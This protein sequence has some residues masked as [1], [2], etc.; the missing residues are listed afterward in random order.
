MR[1]RAAVLITTAVVGVL[2]FSSSSAQTFRVERKEQGFLLTDRYPTGDFQV[3]LRLKIEQQ[4]SILDS[5]GIDAAPVGSW[6]LFASADGHIAFNLWDGRNWSQILSNEVMPWG[7]ETMVTV[8]RVGDAVTV[9][10][11]G[12]WVRKT[13]GTPLSGKPVYVG[14]YSPDA[15]WGS[16]YDIHR[17]AIGQI[18]VLYIGPPKSYPPNFS[19]YRSRIRDDRAILSEGDIRLLESAIRTLKERKGWDVGVAFLKEAEGSVGN[20]MM[21]SFAHSLRA[22]G[23]LPEDYAILAY[24][25]DKMRLYH[26][27]GGF[28]K[29]TTWDAVR[30][31]W[32]KQSKTDSLAVK[33]AG[34]LSEMAG[35]PPIV[36]DAGSK[37]TVSETKTVKA[38]GKAEIGAPGGTVTAGSVVVEVPAGAVI[39]PDTLVVK[40]GIDTP[41]GE[42]GVAVDF[43]HGG[44]LLLKPAK[45][46]YPIPTGWDS[47]RLVAL[48]ALGPRAWVTMPL[49]IDRSKGTATAT[50][51]HF[52]NTVLLDL[53]RTKA[54]FTGAVGGGIGGTIILWA[55]GLAPTT[56]GASVLVAIP[57]LAAGWLAAGSSYDSAQRQGLVGPYPAPGFE[58]YW[59][60]G[61]KQNG[62]FISFMIDKRNGYLIGP[63]VDS[64][65]QRQTF[66]GPA[67]AAPNQS[68]TYKIG[69]RVIEVSLENVGQLDVPIS[70]LAVAG[71]LDVARKFYESLAIETP[72]ST[73]VYVYERL[74]KSKDQAKETNSGEWDGKVLQINAKSLSREPPN[75][76][77]CRA[78]SCHEYW[79]A[80]TSHNGFS[81]LWTGQEEAT[82]V[83]M[84]SL[85]WASPA[86]TPETALMDDFTKLHAWFT[87]TPV[88]RSGLFNVGTD[89]AAETRGY[90]QWPLIKY[91]YHRLGKEALIE[92]IRGKMSMARLDDAVT[93][94]ALAGV[95]AEQT[96]PD[97]APLD[98][99]S[100]GA[101]TTRTGFGRPTL[102]EDPKASTIH[103][104]ANDLARSS[105]ASINAFRVSLPERPAGTPASPIV[106]RREYTER[107]FYSAAERI[108]ASKP[109]NSTKL[110]QPSA[111]DLKKDETCVAL[112]ESWDGSGNMLVMLVTSPVAN[113]LAPPTP[114]G[115]AFLVYRLSPPMNVEFEHLPTVKEKDAKTR[116]TWVPP[117][118]GGALETG[119]AVAAYRLYARK[120]GGTP[121]LIAELSLKGIHLDS[122][123][124]SPSGSIIIP[125]DA[126]S[127]DIAIP[128]TKALEFD[129]FAMASVDGIAKQEGKA[130][131]SPIGWSGGSSLLTA[132]EKC[133][134][135]NFIAQL[136]FEG[137]ITNQ[138]KDDPP[139]VETNLYPV[140]GVVNAPDIW[141][142]GTAEYKSGNLSIKNGHVSFKFAGALKGDA[143]SSGSLLDALNSYN[144]MWPFS[145]GSAFDGITMIEFSADI[146]GNGKLTNGSLVVTHPQFGCTIKF[147]D[148]VPSVVKLDKDI[149]ITYTLD[150]AE[151]TAKTNGHS[152]WMKWIMQSGTSEFRLTKYLGM[153]GLTLNFVRRG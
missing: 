126:K 47:N 108:Y 129:E 15:H 35:E 133:N 31:V 132:L 28:D 105:R 7:Q 97:P 118:L 98:H 10:V 134:S 136:S 110:P 56:S 4:G 113:T 22:D 26:R 137:T 23:K 20:R 111:A 91:I 116:I 78:T 46:V 49:T 123:Y 16:G 54:K 60:P 11:Q 84:E 139:K 127:A 102:I 12:S 119:R 142:F 101:S 51:N 48:R 135:M 87:C 125:A 29:L 149:Q 33:M 50:T 82:A 115:N 73:T 112:P 61:L 30:G 106:A 36:V 37:E 6:S 17:G 117:D 92:V 128:R 40:Q 122:W 143:E 124:K 45:I 138:Y 79:H 103:L 81:E 42:P 150:A 64:R 5:A 8:R 121:V 59:L 66:I 2:S 72:P 93:G 70:V 44:Q 13:L 77:D 27:T 85:V 90:K 21:A 148:I 141:G 52:C 153:R 151:A 18:D 24:L 107:P 104:G 74:G 65:E 88:L 57:F 152:A 145:S 3:Q 86:G 96:V 83:A 41:L 9:Y 94:L 120:A 38:E 131:E 130:L 69:E 34:T 99:P 146:A 62:P 68:L 140:S 76:A 63:H 75:S 32:D 55:T 147:G 100:F 25:G 71:E 114:P 144:P 95:T 109:T 1:V 58:L 53:G 67:D 19:D 89:E 80:V 43:A 39:K 14:D